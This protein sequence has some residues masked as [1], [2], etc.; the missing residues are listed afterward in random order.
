MSHRL[1]QLLWNYKLNL[2]TD[3]KFESVA[4]EVC[5]ST[6]AEVSLQRLFKQSR[7]RTRTHRRRVLKH[8][9]R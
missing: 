2:T 3:P 6:I 1:L 4:T 5:K 9:R 8:A 7:R